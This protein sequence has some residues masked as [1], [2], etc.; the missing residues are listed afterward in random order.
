MNKETKGLTK[1]EII[2]IISQEI[3]H[4]ISEH[5]EVRYELI[6]VM[7]EVFVK[8]DETN[9]I[10]AEIKNL[11]GDF[12]I[13]SQEIRALREAT[14]K[15]S[16]EIKALR[17]DFNIISQEIKALREDFNII[18]QEIKALREATNRNR[19]DFHELSKH[20]DK[21]FNDLDNRLVGLGARWGLMS[22]EAIRNNLRTL[23]TENTEKRNTEIHRKILNYKS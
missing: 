18:S 19:E 6:G 17:E 14:D 21:K 12:N 9:K 22:E 10:L 7:S 11:R 4:L 5:P 1:E 23:N 8:K 15:N 20:M 2:A 16:Q 3:P 13:I